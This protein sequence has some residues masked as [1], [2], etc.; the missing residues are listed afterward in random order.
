LLEELFLH[1][2]LQYFASGTVERYTSDSAQANIRCATLKL[3]THNPNT[4]PMPPLE[5]KPA[6]RPFPFLR[7]PKHIRRQ[8]YEYL[9][10]RTK[11]VP[12]YRG[13]SN[14]RDYKDRPVAFLVLRY[15]ERII[16][17]TCR[18]LSTEA[19]PILEIETMKLGPARLIVA[20]EYFHRIP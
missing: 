11:Y 8:I 9:P 2:T 15:V 17:Q 13:E 19:E 18:Q 10:V 1:S 20:A 7:L 5:H 6:P 3:P 16:V 4:A 14:D 12:G